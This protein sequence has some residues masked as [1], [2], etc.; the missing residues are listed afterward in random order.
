MGYLYVK[1]IESKKVAVRNSFFVNYPFIRV[2]VGKEKKATSFKPGIEWWDKIFTFKAVSRNDHQQI[3]IQARD[4]SIHVFG[5]DWLGEVK[6]D[7]DS[8]G[9][10]DERVHQMWFK[11]GRGRKPHSRSP[12]GYI[13][14]AFQYSEELVVGKRPFCTAPV[15]KVLTF[16]EWLAANNK[17]WASDSSAWFPESAQEPGWKAPDQTLRKS[18]PASN[19]NK[20]L[21]P[22]EVRGNRAAST[23]DPTINPDPVNT[24]YEDRKLSNTRQRSQT[25]PDVRSPS[26]SRKRR[27]QIEQSLSSSGEDESDSEEPRTGN[28]IDLSFDAPKAHHHGHAPRSIL[29]NA[30][31]LSE[32]SQMTEE[33]SMEDKIEGIKRL[34]LATEPTAAPGFQVN[35]EPTFAEWYKAPDNGTIV[36]NPFLDQDNFEPAAYSKS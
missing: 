33:P 16:E 10:L 9:Y 3:I 34:S 27:E 22:D 11:F 4:K 31:S 24:K 1:V 25:L 26:T 30:H 13:H 20:G 15:E 29:K 6:I 36:K 21:S 19:L 7:L 18:A 23:S 32:V 5:S 28:L 35:S 14:L 2:K 17:N 12:R 8:E